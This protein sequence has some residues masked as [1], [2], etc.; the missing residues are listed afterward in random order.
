[1]DDNNM[2]KYGSSQL[3]GVKCDY[4]YQYSCYH[5]QLAGIYLNSLGLL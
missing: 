2:G 4:I 1:M 5:T 3:K